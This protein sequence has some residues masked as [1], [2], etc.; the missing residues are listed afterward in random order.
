MTEDKLL[1][2]IHDMDQKSLMNLLAPGQFLFYTCHLQRQD[3]LKCS[4][5]ASYAY[6]F[7]I[8]LNDQ[9]IA[10]IQGEEASKLTDCLFAPNFS[11]HSAKIYAT[12]VASLAGGDSDTATY[13]G[14]VI[15]N[16][17]DH[18][19]HGDPYCMYLGGRIGYNHNV[20]T[21][22]YPNSVLDSRMV[23]S[24]EW[25]VDSS[26]GSPDG[27]F[28]ANGLNSNANGF[29]PS[30]EFAAGYNTTLVV[31]IA[32][33]PFEDESIIKPINRSEDCGGTVNKGLVYNAPKG[34][35]INPETEI[36][37]EENQGFYHTKNSVT[38]K[39][40]LFGGKLD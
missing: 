9:N 22:G 36:K 6:T 25:A 15:V 4:H 35:I 2:Q 3:S 39:D 37:T 27:N 14:S 23:G 32:E 26:Y 31:G 1:E 29:S 34:D 40:S 7:G 17:A 12:P 21:N 16:N 13:P 33:Q 24:A 38:T 28:A 30:E 18:P 5:Q 20:R 19:S 8:C 10:L 11:P